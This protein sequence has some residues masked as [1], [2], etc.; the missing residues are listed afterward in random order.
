MLLL[1]VDMSEMFRMFDKVDDA[2]ALVD[3]ANCCIRSGTAGGNLELLL[4]LVGKFLVD[5]V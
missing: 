3:N 4:L 5:S 1:E 2:A